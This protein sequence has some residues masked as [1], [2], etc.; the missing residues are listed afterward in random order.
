MSKHAISRKAYLRRQWWFRVCRALAIM[1]FLGAALVIGLVAGLFASVSQ[2]L[3]KDEALSNIRPPTP[4]RILASDGSLLARIYLPD[5]NRELVPYSRMG[6]MID[7]TVAIEDERFFDHPGI[8]LRGIMRAMVKNVKAG[9]SKEGASTVTQQLARNLY[10]SREK[11]VSRKLREMILALELERRYSKQEILETYLNQVYYGSNQ[12]GVQSWGAQMAAHNYFGKN[13]EALTLP[14]AALLAG[15]PKNPRDYNP[16]KFRDRARVRRDLVLRIM[17]ENKQ[18]SKTDYQQAKATEIKVTPEKPLTEMADYHAPYF[19]RH[20]LVEEMK[21]IFG[22]DANNLIYHYGIDIYT[23]LDPRMQ[24]V[25]EETV[26]EQVKKNKFRRIDDGALISID[27]QTGFIKAMVGGTDYRKDQYNIVTQGRRQP[28]SS[29]K[30]FVYTTALMNG[31]TPKTIV[32]DSPRSYPT[33]YGQ[34]WS[35]K[36]SD[37]GYR[38]SIPLEKALWLSRNCAAASVAYDVGIKKIIA[39]AYQMGIKHPLEPHLSTSLGASVV[40]PMEICSAYGTLAN[41]GV[42]HPTT[43]VL[44]VATQDGEVLYE[45]RPQPRRAIPTKIADDMKEVMRGAV[46]RGTGRAARSPF[47]VSGKTGTTNSYRD[48]WFI[49]YTND[50]VTAVWVGNR[51][52]Q[53][54]NR[55]FGGT[56]P[57]P[58]WREY[59]LVAQ[60]IMAAEH[61]RQ[62]ERLA[63]INNI[64]DARQ[65]VEVTAKILEEQKKAEQTPEVTEEN[66]LP[67]QLGKEYTVPICADTGDRSNQWCP[68]KVMVTYVEGS[69]EEPPG[70]HC[71]KHTGPD[72][73]PDA[74]GTTVRG[75]RSGIL[76]SICGETT[77]IATDRCPTVLLR[78]YKNNAP[79][80]T[81]PLHGL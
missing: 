58:I 26:I 18:I 15:L 40:V 42:H 75:D 49:G 60:P 77:K 66:P 16:Y 51:H 38:G 59:M 54:M 70:A 62:K 69:G 39:V 67:P 7:A 33:G 8:D 5:Q 36:N 55:T 81:C 27:P 35:P 34:F 14:E 41:H 43:G 29:F 1:I 47:P 57:A 44:R 24:K 48:A 10:L 74:D 12:F 71:S 11:K 32:H 63:R 23:S 20:I 19:V 76:I 4:T 68:D 56:V 30:P 2:S 13:V 72:A 21:K 52:N 37:G 79:T 6:Y 45:Y 80:E 17:F 9:D 64:P 3:P 73:V 78:R 22:Q 53:P 65:A 31:Y 50:L 25:A 28:G 46:E 61:V